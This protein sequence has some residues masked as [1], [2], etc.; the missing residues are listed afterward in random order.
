MS[1][2]MIY[3]HIPEDN[4]VSDEPNAFGIS[5][6]I[7]QI[8]L[9]D[10]RKHFPLT[11]KY[12]FRF[13]H[14]INKTNVW[15]DLNGDDCLALLYQ[16]KII[17]K[18]TRIS[19]GSSSPHVNIISPQKQPTNTTSFNF[20]DFNPTNKPQDFNPETQPKPQTNKTQEFNLNTQYKSPQKKVQEFDLLFPN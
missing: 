18:V 15:M 9:G 4:D 3:Y 17:L 8:K 13:K 2:T 20:F 12:H 19:W 7:D 16:N 11:G 5:K 14:L 1:Y 10:I 6:P